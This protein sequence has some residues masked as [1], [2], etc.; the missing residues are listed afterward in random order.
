MQQLGE[1]SL[2]KVVSHYL[3]LHDRAREKGT[4]LDQAI[5]FF[6]NRYCPEITEITILNAKNEYLKTRHGI[7][8][9]TRSNYEVGLVLLLKP[10]P[11]KLVHAFTVGDLETS[12]KKY[13]NTRSRRSFRTIFSGFFNW[14]VRHHYCLENPCKRFDKLPKDMTQIALLSL[15]DVQ[16][17]LYAAVCYQDGAAASSIAIGL[18]AG[19]RPSE[20]ADLKPEDIGGKVIRVSGGKLRRKLK[21]SVPISN[22]L[23]AW[24]KDYPFTGLPS[25]WIYKMKTLKKATDARN[26][27]QDII[28]HTSISFQTERDQNE[29][30]TA[31]N[32]GTSVKMMDLHYRNSIDDE[33]I[34]K[35]FW[36]LTPKQLVATKPEVTVPSKAKIAWPSKSQLEKLVWEKPLI[37]AAA[38]LGV[39]DVALR[40]RCVKLGISLP[41]NG[42]WL[43]RRQNDEASMK[44][45]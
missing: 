4:D 1:V 24:L 11:N 39:S 29:A 35:A 22:V 42:H 21:R 30:L 40:K 2:S 36:D 25:G 3:N 20:I 10:D 7:S 17:L 41:A 37:H 27:V 45:A 18:F 23:A 19:L 12:L 38:D 26:W 6:E 32:C 34:I 5:S 9:A 14:A 31:Y 28:R 43:R 8:D 44:P 15:D 33:E 16:R 13:T